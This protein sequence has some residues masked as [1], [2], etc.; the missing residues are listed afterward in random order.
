M[1]VIMNGIWI[2]YEWNMNGIWVSS[3]QPT[4]CYWNWHIYF[5]DLSMN[6][7][8]IFHSYVSLPEGIHELPPRT[9]QKID[10]KSSKDS[11][12]RILQWE[13]QGARFFSGKCIEDGAA[14]LLSQI[15]LGKQKCIEFNQNRL[16]TR[17]RWYALIGLDNFSCTVE[18]NGLLTNW[19]A[20]PECSL[21]RKILVMLV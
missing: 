16:I 15:C 9:P 11:R 10:Q 1:A 21:Y 20:F 4:D 14:S 12:V 18:T 19:L 13:N 3:D 7:M 17:W 6:S 5:V 2:G 8:V